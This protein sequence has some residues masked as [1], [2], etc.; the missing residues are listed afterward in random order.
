MEIER[1]KTHQVVLYYFSHS[2]NKISSEKT[3]QQH[4]KTKAGHQDITQC[5]GK[6]YSESIKLCA[7]N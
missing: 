1:E 5:H 4:F 6:K 3:M 2:R 7:Y